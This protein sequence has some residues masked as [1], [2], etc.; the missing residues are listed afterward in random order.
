MLKRQGNKSDRTIMMEN[1]I[2]NYFKNM[3]DIELLP[4]QPVRTGI[5]DFFKIIK[6]EN[7]ILDCITIEIKQSAQDFYSG[8]GLN[9]V[10]ISNYVAVPSELVGFAIEFLRENYSYGNEIGVLEVDEKGLVRTVI[11]PHRYHDNDYIDTLYSWHL[12]PYHL[13]YEKKRVS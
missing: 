12:T 5:V 8:H 4:E 13:K 10:G 6:N 1:S 9:F 11:Y 2:F 7:K 3:Y